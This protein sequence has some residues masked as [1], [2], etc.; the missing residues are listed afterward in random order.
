MSSATPGEETVTAA[1]L[2]IGDEILSGRT[3]D[4]NIGYIAEYLTGDRHRP[5]RGAGRAGRRGRDRRGGERAPRA[6]TTHVFTTGGIGPTHDD[7][8]ADADRQGV[9]RRHRRRSARRGDAA[10]A[11]PARPTSTRRGCAWRAF[12]AGADADREPG[13]E[14][15]G[16][17]A[18]AT[19]TSW[20]ACR[21]SCR[22]CSMRWRR[23][24]PTGQ[25]MLSR[26]IAGRPGGGRHRR[27]R[28]A[29][30]SGASR[31]SAS[32]ATR[33]SSRR[34]RLHHDARPALARRGAARRGRSRGRGDAGDV[35][36][37]LPELPAHFPCSRRATLPADAARAMR[38]A[39]AHG[40]SR[41]PNRGRTRHSRS[42]GT[43]SI[44]TRAR[45]PG[46]SPGRARGR[47]SSAS[48]AAA[49]CRRRSSPASSASA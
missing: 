35:R 29:P 48:P 21:R 34:R 43:S 4:K 27:R 39:S 10:R 32:A 23:G 11:H 3:K 31:T 42:P 46:G 25:K 2:V 1:V 41:W 44:A 5:A 16:L 19:S 36:R 18:S 38:Q 28:S 40:G 26:S 22:R 12:P 17:L 15:A 24:S 7:I 20:P 14:G 49:W 30:S 6:A 8:T 9:R 37:R 47:R 13:L 45:S 33:P